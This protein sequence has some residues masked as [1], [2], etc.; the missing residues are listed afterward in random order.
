MKKLLGELHLSW[1]KLIV[2]AILAGVY[3]GIVALIPFLED[4]SLEDISISFEWWIFFGILMIMN[5]TSPMDAALKCFVFFLI[6][7][8]L[9]YLVQVPFDPLGFGLFQ[10]Y[11]RWFVWT[12][13]TLPMGYIGYHMKK[14]G[15]TALLILSPMLLLL[16]WHIFHFMQETIS[17]FPRHLLSLLFCIA[18]MFFYVDG[19]VSGRGERKV[20]FALCVLILAACLLIGFAQG[21]R[22]YET[23]LKYSDEALSFDESYR[24]YLTDEEYG[25]VRV[26]KEELDGETVYA[27]NA[28]FRKTGKTTMILE[29]GAERHTFELEIG[30]SSYTMQETE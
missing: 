24:V 18:T 10:Y 20:G 3:T 4:T 12:M 2:F 13:F 28:A 27:L 21:R 26:E 22:V 15:W 30:R 19:I 17:F 5:S 16:G 14:G 9:V 25:E 1:K 11:K 29:K 6:S 8:P 7:Q 23:T